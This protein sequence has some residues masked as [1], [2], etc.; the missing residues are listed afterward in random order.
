MERKQIDLDFQGKKLTFSTGHIALRADSAVQ[1][2]IGDTVVL[3]VVT[4]DKNDA[5]KDYFPLG[6]EYL[7]KY[8]AGGIISGSRF[9]KREARPSESATLIARQVDHSI[10]S[11]FP[12]GFKKPVSVA[13]LVL[14]YDSEYHPENLAVTAASMALMLS[15]VPFKAPSASVTVGLK[16]D[17]ELIL[18]PSESLAEELETKFIVSATEGR[19]LNIE[20]YANE[21]SED[22][23][24][25]VLDFAVKSMQP[26]VDVQH[27]FQK[28]VGKEKQPFAETPV[29]Q[30]IIDMVTE[31]YSDQISD[32]IYGEGD[33]REL[34]ANMKKEIVE[35]STEEA[36]VSDHE[37]D[38][39]V[40]YVARKIMR[41]NVLDK[42]KRSS[43]R[44]LDE[45]RK[46]DIETSLLP[47][48]HG[49]ALFTRGI[50]QTLSIATL[51]SLRLSQIL[52]SFE[53]EEIKRFMHHYNG[54]NYSMGEA[55]RFNYYPGRREIGHGHITENAFHKILPSAEKFPY[56]IRVVSEIMSQNGSSS[57]AA[58]TGTS[59]ALMDAGVPIDKHVSGVA[60]GLV[61]N[62]DDV[63]D[64]KL[65]TDMEDIEDFYGDMDFKVTGTKDG[66]TAIQMDNK[67][68]GVP[69]DIIKEAFRRAAVGR[70]FII[71]KMIKVIDKPR[72]ELSA[73]AP[74]VEIVK[75]KKEKIGELIGPGGKNIKRIMEVTGEGTDVNIEDDGTVTIT[76]VSDEARKKAKQMIEDL[77]G[78]AEVGKTYDG[79]VDKVMNYGAFVDVTPAIS[80]LVHVS[81][82]S[83]EFV[84]DPTTVV[85]EGQKVRVKVI[86]IDKEGRIQLSIKKAE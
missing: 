76:A 59:L 36:P 56:T 84:K 5:E 71:E 80:G 13:I 14:S 11:L 54:P 85:K 53:G 68:Q 8:Y 48:V 51:G 22:K 75:I 12:K 81:E 74:K 65:L 66:I 32:A 67:L 27:K 6:V 24:D 55:G 16:A 7:E 19:I 61:T 1:V 47:R 44:K 57:M 78:E 4:V 26:L 37:A 3:A 17:G 52:E 42:D 25:E 58:A 43:G 10:R 23:M 86:G 82:I 9:I 79:V 63:T 77:V 64:Y 49:S 70:Q 45:I 20:G 50:T 15:S 30:E 62:D 60:I 83:D 33:R 21:L 73:Y 69:V 39:A 41:K 28:E 34:I 35:N 2:Q 40:E 72:A 18:N 29:A 38:T 31:K 46:I